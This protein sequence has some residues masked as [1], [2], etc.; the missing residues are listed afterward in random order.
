MGRDRP[1]NRVGLLLLGPIQGERRRLL[2]EPWGRDGI[3]FQG[4]EGDSTKHAIE[5]RGKQRIEDRPQPVIM[6]RFSLEAGLEQ[7]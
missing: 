2:M 4:V 1:L 6:E 7:G 3:D 5:I